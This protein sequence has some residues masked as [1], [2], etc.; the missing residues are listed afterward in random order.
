MPKRTPLPPFETL[1]SLFSYDPDTGFVT[2]KVAK[3]PR[4]KTAPAGSYYEVGGRVGYVTRFGYLKVSVEGVPYAL[5]RVIWKLQTRAEPP[6][7]IDHINRVRAD[8]R[9]ANLREATASVNASNHSIWSAQSALPKTVR[10]KQYNGRWTAQATVSGATVDLGEFETA[11]EAMRAYMRVSDHE[12]PAVCDVVT[13]IDED[14]M[15]SVVKF[16]RRME[17][18]SAT[19]DMGEQLS[20]EI[21]EHT[22]VV[23]S[24]L[25]RLDPENFRGLYR[26]HPLSRHS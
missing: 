17:L 16:V 19:T 4:K 11:A 26:P 14:F 12:E 2:A 25:A 10:R 9:W 8:N 21:R 18:L 6:E 3:K 22:S 24:H 23:G 7:Y 20:K 1:D 5:H 15:E 13:L